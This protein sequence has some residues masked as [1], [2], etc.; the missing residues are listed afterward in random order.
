MLVNVG[1]LKVIRFLNSCDASG[2]TDSLNGML[3]DEGEC[4]KYLVSHVAKCGGVESEVI[5]MVGR[6]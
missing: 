3:M 5:C 4:F 6:V 1:K 2:I